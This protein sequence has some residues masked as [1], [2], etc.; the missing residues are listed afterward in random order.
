MKPYPFFLFAAEN[1]AYTRKASIAG[2]PASAFGAA[3]TLDGNKDSLFPLPSNTN[4]A[5][6]VELD[7]ARLVSRLLIFSHDSGIGQFGRF[8][9]L[10]HSL[11]LVIIVALLCI[12]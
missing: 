1:V 11:A 4:N 12:I 2:I 10:V 7:N 3:Y 5:L 8:S 6:R 9:I